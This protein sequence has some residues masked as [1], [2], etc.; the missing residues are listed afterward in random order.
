MGILI[1]QSFD[2]SFQDWRPKTSFETFSEKKC[3]RL[4]YVESVSQGGEEGKH[5]FLLSKLW[6][7]HSDEFETF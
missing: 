3:P 4:R 2:H 5:R 1:K 6:V 7:N